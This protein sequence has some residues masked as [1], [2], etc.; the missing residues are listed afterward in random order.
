MLWSQWAKPVLFS[1]PVSPDGELPDLPAPSWASEADR[2]TMLIVD[3]P[4]E[5]SVLEGLALAGMGY[6]PV[7]LY[8]GVY[9]P[10]KD[11]MVIDVTSIV[12]TLYQGA[13]LLASF[14]LHPEAPPAFLLDANRM[15]GEAHQAGRYD[16]RW[17]IFPQDMPSADFLLAQGI[18]E[19]Y[20]RTKYPQNALSHIL[21]RYQEKGIRIFHSGDN[22]TLK[23][24][25]V[26]KPSLFRSCTYRFQ[27]M[28][29]LTI[30][31]AGGFGGTIPEAT[32]S[33]GVRHYGVG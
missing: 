6:R 30:N 12:K 10:Y 32:Q 3:L 26:V 2:K 20:V 23:E 27:T 33:S 19:I 9:T 29:G 31:A 18:Q 22:G 5:K 1:Q 13:G 7:P 11:A 21:K 16:N 14:S 17:C 28:L 8:N 24:L 15:K 4:G 25:M